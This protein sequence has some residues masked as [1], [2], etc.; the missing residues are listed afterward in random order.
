MKAQDKG[1]YQ[2]IEGNS[3]HGDLTLATL[4]ENC[5]ISLNAV[6][7]V[8]ALSPHFRTLFPSPIQRLTCT[9]YK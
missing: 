3:E 5:T 8:R 4:D 1:Q 9:R 7:S 6:L 2:V